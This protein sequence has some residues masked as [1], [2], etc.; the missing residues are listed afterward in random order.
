MYCPAKAFAIK[1]IPRTVFRNPS[2]KNKICLFS[3]SVKFLFR[4]LYKT[5]TKQTVHLNNFARKSGFRLQFLWQSAFSTHHCWK[6]LMTSPMRQTC[7]QNADQYQRFPGQV[8]IC[9]VHWLTYGRHLV[10]IK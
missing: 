8:T 5:I 10:K 3:I 1:S 7:T 4:F 2:N 6:S 9:I